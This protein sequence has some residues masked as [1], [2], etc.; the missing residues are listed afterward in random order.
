MKRHFVWFTVVLVPLLLGGCL[1]NSTRLA[2]VAQYDL[3]PAPAA[4]G[5]PVIPL[6][7]ID[8]QAPSWLGTSAM[9][10]RLAY[11]NNERRQIFVESRW[12]APPAELL[13][14][15]LRRHLISSAAGSCRVRVEVDEF[16][17]VFDAP[18]SSRSLLEARISLVAGKGD[19]VLARHTVSLSRPATSTDAR[20]G[21]VAFSG[22]A[23]ELGKNISEWLAMLATNQAARVGP[24]R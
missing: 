16:A 2:D 24:C 6:R 15:N 17:Q 18:A 11:A 8:V 3:G 22:M 13:E 5:A 12:V 4:A 14:I 23:T 10:Y 21:V 19:Q 9:Q 7:S 1:G 20:G